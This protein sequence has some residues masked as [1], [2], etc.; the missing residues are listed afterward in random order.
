MIT[1]H[2]V[3][4]TE[5]R[6]IHCYPAAPDEVYYLR[7]RHRHTFKVEVSVQQFHNERDVE[8]I[9]LKN[10]LDT[11]VLSNLHSRDLGAMSCEAMAEEIL[12]RVRLRYPGRG[13]SVDVLEDG[14]NGA[15]LAYFPEPL[16]A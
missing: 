10:W 1:R 6:A 7:G 5:F 15:S 3:V 11:S 4:R 2:A 16:Q 9:M 8:Y 13:L 12:E 14:E